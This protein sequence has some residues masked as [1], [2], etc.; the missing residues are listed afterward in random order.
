MAQIKKVVIVLSGGADSATLAYWAKS[1]GHHI[2]PITFNYG[3]I[4]SKETKSAEIISQKLGTKIKVVDISSLKQ[5]FEGS[6]V[7]VDKNIPM[8]SQFESNVIVP[9]RNAIFLSIAVAYAITIGATTIMYGA[10]KSDEPFYPDCRKEFVDAFQNAAKLGTDE[11]IK[12]ENPFYKISKAE[13]IRTG[14][15]LKVPY[16]VTWSCYLD[17]EQH[18][19]T[20][21]SCN[22][23]KNAFKEANIPDPTD[24]FEK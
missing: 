8:P 14:M 19:G 12:I 10:H 24:Y 11:N 13:I 5:I 6:T 16:D 2:Y 22:N 21:E 3:Q 9:F 17:G 18:C 15:T 20:C 1:K 7:L 23:R 4:A